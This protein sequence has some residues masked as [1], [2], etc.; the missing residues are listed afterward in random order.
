MEDLDRRES[1][2]TRETEELQ[3]MLWRGHQDHQGD[4]V[5]LGQRELMVHQDSLGSRAWLV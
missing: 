3:E 1:E 2:V 4:L 5:S